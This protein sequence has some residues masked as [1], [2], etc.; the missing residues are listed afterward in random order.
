MNLLKE[1]YLTNGKSG[2]EEPIKAIAWREM[3]QLD[4]V[5]EE[6]DFGNMFIVKGKASKYA[7]VVAHLDEVHIPCDQRLVEHDGMISAED[8]DGQPVGIGA[9]DKNGIWI[10]LRLLHEVDTLKVAF[11]VQEEKDG[12]LAGCRGS[13][14]C[15]IGWFD[16]VRYIIQC[17]RKGNSDIVTFS[18]KAD[19]RLCDDGFI[20]EN[21]RT[22][23]GYMPANGGSTDVVALKRRGLPIPC[24]N[25]SCG[26]YNAHT[27]KEYTVVSELYNCYVFVKAIVESV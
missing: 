3:S 16:D 24:C 13:K 14:A 23:Y 2:H 26:Y 5:V 15:D 20:P 8:F 18:E 25:I 6:D 4:A 1:L 19:I 12:D 21:I 9:D 27:E 22:K 11:F 7:C 17:D 10:A